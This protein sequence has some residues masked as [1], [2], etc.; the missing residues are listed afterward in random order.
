MNHFTRAG[1]VGAG[2]M[3]RGI[4]YVLAQ[5][6][7]DVCLIDND[8]F[9]LENGLNA[10]DRL[11]ETSIE[12]QKI[13]NFEAEAISD[14]ISQS[15]DLEALA[16]CDLMIEAVSED[17]KIKRHIFSIADRLISEEGLLASNTSS[18]SISDIASATLNK[19]RV[20]GLHF[21]NPAHIMKLL[22]IVVHADNS[23][24]AVELAKE[25][26][27]SLRK[28]CI[29]VNDSPGFATSRLGI[30]FCL[31]A[32]RMLEQGVAGVEELDRAMKLGYG[33]PMGPLMLSDWV[34]LDVRLAISE[35]L[36]RSLD[37]HVFEPPNLL[38]R[39]V[40]VGFLGKKSGTGFYEWDGS[41]HLGVSQSLI[42]LFQGIQ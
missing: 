14:C 35:H 20:L 23:L 29:V 32:I 41:R 16:G 5:A 17:I 7:I 27:L 40:R 21:F 4:A 42:D 15:R 34:G 36:Y 22:E 30:S 24:D 11:L 9:A 39:M 12:K 6:G 25:L 18:L 3:G 2:T 8:P 38:R 37:S 13:N 19:E 26:A 33:H 28:E 10:I 31:E 1:V